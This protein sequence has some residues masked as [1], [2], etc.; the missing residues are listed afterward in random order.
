MLTRLLHAAIITSAFY[1]MMTFSQSPM[2]QTS[3]FSPLQSSTIEV[4][5]FRY[6]LAKVID[7]ILEPV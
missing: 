2:Q 7:F 6:L 1:L 3:L 5:R 4:E